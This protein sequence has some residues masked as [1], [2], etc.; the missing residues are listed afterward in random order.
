[1]H[2]VLENGVSA[3]PNFDGRFLQVSGI[4]FAFNHLK[5]SGSRIDP[6]LIKIHDE[7]LNFDKVH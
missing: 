1:M 4:Q 3:Y 6:A 7:Y 2:Q 5:P